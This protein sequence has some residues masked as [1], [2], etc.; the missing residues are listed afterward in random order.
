MSENG[1]KVSIGVPAQAR[2]EPPKQ[3]LCIKWGTK[4][5]PEYANRLYGMV[6]RNVSGPLRFV[7]MVDDPEG[8][9]PEI[10]PLA[11]PDLSF[12]LRPKTRGIWGKSRLWAKSLGDLQGPVLFMD[13]DLVVVGSLDRFFSHGDPDRVVLARNP[14]RPLERLGQT[15]IYRFPVGGLTALEEMF[16]SDP[17]AIADRYTYEQRFVTRNAPGGV[18]FWP[19]GWVDF[20]KWHCV[21]QFPLN[22][23]QAPRPRRNAAVVV[24]A[25]SLNPPDALVGRWNK[26]GVH[27]P[28]LEHIKAGLRGERS[29]SLFKHTHDFL[30]PS[31]WIAEHWHE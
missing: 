20:F 13:L 23:F 3:V 22:Y 17:Q 26:R 5:G 31:T 10:E 4:Y 15:S 6:R 21:P 9:R 7:C 16:L 11:L 18:T 12:T 28:P 14:N 30:W 29:T 24:F 19:R 2:S 25:G 1:P 8:L 27:R